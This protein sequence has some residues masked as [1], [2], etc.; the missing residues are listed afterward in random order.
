[1][2]IF[3]I[4]QIKE[5][6]MLSHASL[7]KEP[8]RIDMGSYDYSQAEQRCEYK[9]NSPLEYNASTVGGTQTFGIDGKPWD[10]DADND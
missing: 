8:I 1:M 10:S 5:S 6:F 3:G 4:T 7:S 9:G 2:P